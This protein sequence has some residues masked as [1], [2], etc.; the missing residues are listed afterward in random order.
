MKRGVLF[1]SVLVFLFVGTAG[2]IP[3]AEAAKPIILGVPTSLGYLE[4]KEGLK[5]VK[6][7]VDEI[8]KAGGVKVG[9]EKRSF[10]VVAIDARGG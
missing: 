2:M 3:A 9:N 6:M 7:A 8:N 1:L 4:G 10:K 5:C